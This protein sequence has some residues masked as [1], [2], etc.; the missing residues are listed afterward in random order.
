[1][2]ARTLPVLALAGALATVAAEPAFA[3]SLQFDL[4]DEASGS[5]QCRVR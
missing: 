4:G 2:A 3:Q 1:M 5:I